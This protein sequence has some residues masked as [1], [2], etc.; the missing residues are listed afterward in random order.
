MII[1]IMVLISLGCLFISG[2]GLYQIVKSQG[3]RIK[4]LEHFIYPEFG[5]ERGWRIATQP[6][7]GPHEL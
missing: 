4:A 5:E 3:N 7:R 1:Y 6:V 2:V